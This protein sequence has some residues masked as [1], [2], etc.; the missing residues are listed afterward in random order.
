MIKFDMCC[1]EPLVGTMIFPKAE[2]FC[3]VCGSA[4]GIFGAPDRADAT[5]E[6]IAR[7]KD[8]ER[9]FSTIAKDCIPPG[10]Q[11]VGCPEC[12]RGAY[13]QDHASEEELA[14]SDAAYAELCPW[15]EKE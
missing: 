4:Y 6:L 7:H 11:R 5:P 14:A 10:S 2:Y 9:K 1:G 13:H 8:I 3:T 12:V 15:E